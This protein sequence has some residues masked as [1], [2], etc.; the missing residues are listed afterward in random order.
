VPVTLPVLANYLQGKATA[1]R[2][3]H[4]I[5]VTEHFHLPRPDVTWRR[6]ILCGMFAQLDQEDA[7]ANRPFRTAI[8]TRKDTNVPGKGF[9]VSLFNLR[10]I[11][12][13][14]TLPTKKGVHQNEMDALVQYYRP[15]QP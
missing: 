6:H 10:Q 5:D 3:V 2:P 8:V 11:P 1:G 14:E 7:N 12:I 15:T 4:Y 9:F 13:P